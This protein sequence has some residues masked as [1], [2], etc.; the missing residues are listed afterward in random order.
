LTGYGVA[1]ALFKMGKP[2]SIFTKFLVPLVLLFFLYNSYQV[3]LTREHEWQNT[4]ALQKYLV[5]KVQP[6][7]KVLTEEGGVVVLSLYDKIFPPKD[8]TTFD[9]IDYSGLQ[10]EKGYKQ[11]VNDGYF[12]YIQLDNQFESSQDLN[13]A[14]RKSMVPN[15]S[16]AYKRDIFEVYEKKDK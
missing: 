15:Y 1:V 6:G 5:Q 12:N 14:I 3:L 4:T 2:I 7:D 9:W 8:I 16:L 11:A 13:S 10:G